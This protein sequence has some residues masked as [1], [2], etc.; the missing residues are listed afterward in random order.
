MSEWISIKKDLPEVGVP[1]L[2]LITW[3]KGTRFQT[4]ARP[5]RRTHIVIGGLYHCEKFIYYHNQMN[6]EEI[7]HVSHWLPLPREHREPC[8]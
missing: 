8:E 7:K 5:L 2:L 6:H 1:C 3:P 4:I